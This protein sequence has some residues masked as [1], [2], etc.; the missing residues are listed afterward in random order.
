MARRRLLTLLASTALLTGAFAGPAA[1]L[2]LGEAASTTPVEV[3]EVASAVE[4]V[5]SEVVE[6]AV[7]AEATEVVDAVEASV[8]VVEAVAPERS[9][10]PQGEST[11]TTSEPASPSSDTHD[12]T[13]VAAGGVTSAPPIDMLIG[14]GGSERTPEPSAATRLDTPAMT[15]V[16][17]TT[18]DVPAPQVAPMPATAPAPATA[19]APSALVQAIDGLPEESAPALALIALAAL[20]AAGAGTLQTARIE[21]AA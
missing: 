6:T 16:E 21:A 5:V 14:L 1:A 11:P 13:V 15:T 17:S 4:D 2:D 7:P 18:G 8:P 12:N 9:A 10:A 3:A 19:S 20:V